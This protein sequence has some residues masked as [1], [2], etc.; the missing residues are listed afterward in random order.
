M[1]DVPAEIAIYV[2]WPFCR[3]KCPYCDFNSHV[4]H[5]PTD[6][7]AFAAALEK[8]LHAFASLL[9]GRQVGS[10]FFGGGTPSLMP[11]QAVA[12]VLGAVARLW[13]L[14]EHAEITLEAN[15]TSAEA[16]NFTGY[17]QAGV[18][19][20][21][22]GVQSL[23]DHDLKALGRLHTA[24]EALAAFD[25]AARIF[26]R[27]SFD[28]IYARPHQTVAQWRNELSHALAIQQGHMSLYQLTIEPGTRFYDLHSKGAL[29]VPDEETSAALFDLTQELTEA[30]G[31]FAYEVSNHAAPGHESRHNLN[32][33]RYGDY[34]GI[35]PGAHSRLT[36]NAG[37]R[38]AVSSERHPETWLGLVS[39]TGCGWI[40]QLSL[41]PADR[42][43]EMLL[44]GLRL[45][46][47]ISIG[48]YREIAGR[49]L[50]RRKIL[51]LCDER[52]LA[53]DTVTG[54]LAATPRGRRLLNTLTAELA[55][56]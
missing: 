32:Y 47:G 6:D 2:H 7:T 19:R 17:R 43:I 50:D 39:E 30:R 36:L 53:H 27:V 20:L 33:W 18:N 45:Q 13:R 41:A 35:G 14:D 51:Q 5:A 28:L 10:I 42:G 25:L 3:A 37:E 24:Q 21:S 22:L 54:R 23:N 4:R 49:D 11:P 52:L 48:R 26:P 55:L 40:E 31:L 16:K 46:E 9:A 15:P 56:A 8:E 29:S 34:A 38:L 44:M 12:Q 1:T